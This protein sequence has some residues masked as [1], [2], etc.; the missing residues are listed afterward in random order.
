M[1]IQGYK[2]LLCLYEGRIIMYIPSMA[3]LQVDL[4]KILKH[5][6]TTTPSC[7]F[8]MGISDESDEIANVSE[9]MDE[10]FNFTADV[11]RQENHSL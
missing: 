10:S 4:G 9:Y 6:E 1:D 3:N 5:I 8:K 11:Y 7:D 2:A